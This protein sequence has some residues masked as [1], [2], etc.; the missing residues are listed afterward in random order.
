MQP[1]RH[2][3]HR[4]RRLRR[5]QVAQAEV[6]RWRLEKMQFI[7]RSSV[8][9]LILLVVYWVMR[10]PK[11]A[12]PRVRLDVLMI[13]LET[14]HGRVVSS[15]L[16]WE[17]AT[18]AHVRVYS[19]DVLYEN[20]NRTFDVMANGPSTTGRTT[21]VLIPYSRRSG[22]F[23]LVRELNV[24]HERMVYSFPRARGDD[25]DDL[26]QTVRKLADDV[27][28]QCVKSFRRLMDGA[29]PKDGVQ[30]ESIVYYLCDTARVVKRNC[31][32]R[33]PGEIPFDVVHG[34][35]AKDMLALLKIGAMPSDMM[36]GALLAIHKL[37]LRILP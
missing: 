8:L 35:G 22:A 26:A 7:A 15:E 6:R 30:M 13:A 4:T 33:R 14:T 9:P 3:S 31:N 21:I 23:T 18:D 19:R 17:G 24:A 5:E 10:A 2:P 1:V 32:E 11:R 25:D 34:V 29:A 12:E 27:C 28:V 36:G 37:G 16:V 20:G